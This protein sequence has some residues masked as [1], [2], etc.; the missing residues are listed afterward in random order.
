MFEKELTYAGHIKKFV[1]TE[2]GNLGW[3]VRVEQDSRVLQKVCYT[4][5]HRVERALSAL[6]SEVVELERDG[7]TQVQPA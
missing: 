3:E 1:I 5:W 4:D 6:S 7:W 2:A